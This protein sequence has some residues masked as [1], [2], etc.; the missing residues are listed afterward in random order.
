M[1]RVG[2][3]HEYLQVHVRSGEN[4]FLYTVFTHVYTQPATTTRIL[5][6][7]KYIFFHPVALIC[8]QVMSLAAF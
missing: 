6:I 5:A 3:T 1:T 2:V 8:S 4:H 7:I